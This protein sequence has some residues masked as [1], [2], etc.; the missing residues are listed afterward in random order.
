LKTIM[1]TQSQTAIG[2]MNEFH[3][4]LFNAKVKEILKEIGFNCGVNV[5]SYS[6]LVN[7]NDLSEIKRKLPSRY[8]LVDGFGTQLEY[9]DIKE[10]C[11]TDK[12]EKDDCE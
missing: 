1:K 8:S 4:N 2:L 3:N 10:I 11:K 6:I 7:N 9:Y 5:N 12:T